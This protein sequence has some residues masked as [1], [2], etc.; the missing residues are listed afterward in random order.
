M[1]YNLIV[2]ILYKNNIIKANKNGGNTNV[3]RKIKNYYFRKIIA[4]MLYIYDT[5][6][7]YWI[8]R[9]IN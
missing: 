1:Y 9:S 3:K 8:V 4:F 7:M 2:Y 6:L 5:Y